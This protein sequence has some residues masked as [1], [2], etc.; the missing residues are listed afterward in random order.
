MQTLLKQSPTERTSYR[1]LMLLADPVLEKLY[2]E[3]LRSPEYVVQWAIDADYT[4]TLL[5]TS[6]DIIILDFALYPQDALDRLREIKRLSPDSEVIVLSPNDDV[7]VAIGAF[8]AGVAD[9]FLKPT[10]PETLAWSIEKALRGK[11]FESTNE[12]LTA[13]LLIFRAAHNISISENDSKMR[14]IVMKNLIKILEA[15]GGIWIWTGANLNQG[16]P[17]TKCEFF[18]TSQQQGH[19]ILQTFKNE[20]ANPLSQTFET[21]LTSHPERWLRDRYVWIPLRDNWMGG[22]FLFNV[23]APADS[24][25]QARMEFLVRNLEISLDNHRRYLQAKQLAYIDDL[26]GLFNS[27]YLDVDLNAAIEDY[28]KTGQR[29]GVLFIDIDHFKKVNDTHGHVV[30]SQLLVEVGHVFK[31]QLRRSDHLFRYGGDEFIAILHHTQPKE[32]LEAA[33]RI[34]V[35]VERQRFRIHGV[36]VQ[37]TVSIGVSRFPDH[38]QDKKSIIALADQAMYNSKNNGR[39]AVF[40]AVLRP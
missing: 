31:K 2:R 4:S 22:I 39:N 13:D 15:Q 7:R 10:N 25:V 6:F 29:F 20:L 19:E 26:T 23:K 28:A 35:A 37:I 24:S 1:V 32:A 36:E 16:N 30:G 17:I 21:H 9:Y 18:Q 33:E 12:V 11:Q 38:A 27:R 40:E 5:T 34:R 14:D 3:R 8:Q